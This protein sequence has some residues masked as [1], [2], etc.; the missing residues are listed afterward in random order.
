MEQNESVINKMQRKYWITKQTV[1]RK[2]GKKDDDC[3]VAS[4]SELDAKLELF[5]SIQQTTS[6]LLKIVARYLNNLSTLAVEENEMG[7]FMKE[8]GKID[9]TRAGKMMMAVGTS[10][11]Y[12]GQQRFAMQTPLDRLYQKLETFHRRAITD[13][14]QTVQR[15]ERS[16]TEYRAALNWLKD[17]SQELDPDMY[18]HMERFKKVQDLVKNSKSRFDRLKA[19]C[20]TKIDV[21]AASRSNMF[22]NLLL[23]YEKSLCEFTEKCANTFTVISN[24]FKG[25]QS[26]DFCVVK[27]LS[28]LKPGSSIAQQVNDINDDNLLEFEEELVADEKKNNDSSADKENVDNLLNIETQSSHDLLSDFISDSA[29]L[30]ST[31]SSSNFFMP[32]QLLLQQSKQTNFFIEENKSALQ[33]IPKTAEKS[34]SSSTKSNSWFDLFAE[35][36]P[37]GNPDSIN[38]IANDQHKNC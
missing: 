28:D 9:K 8:Y 13:T 11:S 35:L 17:I 27:E 20:I 31:L 1:F 15:M 18:K 4:D 22:S 14:L 21:L 32:S 6:N 2:L 38:I 19:V 30:P 12:T 10:V 7:S 37:L 24:S 33:S 23:L 36:D 25:Y 16:R 3:V 5:N 26:Y 34:S 29:P